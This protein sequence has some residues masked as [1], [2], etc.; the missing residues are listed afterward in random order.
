MCK[1][2]PWFLPRHLLCHKINNWSLAIWGVRAGYYPVRL[3]SSL[4]LTLDP[5]SYYLDTI[6]KVFI[7][8]EN[9]WPPYVL[10]MPAVT[11]VTRSP[12]LSCEWLLSLSLSPLRG[13]GP[14]CSSQ[15][16]PASVS[17]PAS[18]RGR[19]RLTRVRTLAS[20]GARVSLSPGLGDL[21]LPVTC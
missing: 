1:E 21:T 10:V 16:E 3:K 2:V 12:C 11:R 19:V 4:T 6:K 17:W 9:P 8:N 15:P 20:D 13:E 14:L 5:R 7:K 18:S